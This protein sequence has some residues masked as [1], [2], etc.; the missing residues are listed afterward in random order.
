M[1]IKYFHHGLWP[2]PSP[3]T[4]FVTWNAFGFAELG[5]DF[6]LLTV[7]NTSEPIAQ[8]LEQEFGIPTPVPMRLLGAGPFRRSHRVVHVLAFW[9][10]LFASWDVLMTRNLGFLPW[11][12]LLRG[13]RGGRVIFES[14]DFYVDA[15]LRDDPSGRSAEKQGRR[16]RRWLPRVDGVVC[17]SEPQ[18]QYYFQSF[19]TQRFFTAVSGVKPSNRRG[20]RRS[21]GGATIGYLGSFDADRYDLDLVLRSI[22]LVEVPGCRLLM[23]GARNAAEAEAMRERAVSLGVGDR[24]EVSAWRSPRELEAIKARLDLGLAPLAITPRNRI[25]T[26][27][28]VLEYLAYGIPTVASDLPGIR[29][30]LDAGPCGLVVEATPESWAAGITRVLTEPALAASLSSAALI[31]AT[32]LSWGRRAG[33]I[34]EFLG[35]R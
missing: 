21:G 15:T 13:L 10:L 27:L 11:A 29:Y 26:P 18:R 33:R 7:A 32:E 22:G 2:S 34:L 6:E 12:L 3:S 5:A 16:E 17:V 30:L 19:P 28:K 31:R 1:R 4:T 24:V 14:H 9:R 35:R 20:A 23:V 25:G 8:V